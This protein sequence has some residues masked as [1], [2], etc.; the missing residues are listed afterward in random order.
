MLSEEGIRQEGGM[1]SVFAMIL[2]L[3]VSALED[4]DG[5]GTRGQHPSPVEVSEKVVADAAHAGHAL[6]IHHDV[7]PVSKFYHHYTDPMG[8]HYHGWL[9]P[10]GPPFY[11]QCFDATVY[12]R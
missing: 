9:P 7:V 8:S 11:V 10:Y 2:L 1:S 6:C 4:L 3:L 12:L 5:K